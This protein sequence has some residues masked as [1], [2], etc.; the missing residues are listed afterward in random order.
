MACLYGKLS[1]ELLINDNLS[2]I[3][4]YK[5]T[6]LPTLNIWALIIKGKIITNSREVN[7]H[8]GTYLQTSAWN[9]SAKTPPIITS[10]AFFSYVFGSFYKCCKASSR[11]DMHNSSS[12]PIN[13]ATMLPI[14]GRGVGS[15]GIGRRGASS[16]SRGLAKAGREAT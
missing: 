7:Y 1:I 14:G 15:R 12:M 11:M 8:H 10:F 2:I 13:N 16:K 4:S 9:F 6:N 5:L 3:Y